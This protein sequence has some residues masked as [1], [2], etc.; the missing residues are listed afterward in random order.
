MEGPETA[1]G[2]TSDVVVVGAGFA[3]LSAALTLRRHRHTVT[4]LDGGPCR[5]QYAEEVHG[6]LGAKGVSGEELRRR[7]WDQV[8]EVG[9]RIVRE[10]VVEASRD[11]TAFVLAGE[12]GGRWR[13]E[14]VLIATGVRD[15]YPEIGGFE[16][17]YGRSVHVCPHCDGYEWRDQPI[18]VIDWNESALP[19]ALKLTHWSD[20][21]TLV[22]DGRSPALRDEERAELTRAGIA[23][24]TQTVDRFR[25]SDGLLEALEFADGSTL[26]VRAAFF[27][28]GQEYQNDIAAQLGCRLEDGEAVDVDDHLRTSVPGVWAAGDV[29]GQ[30][31]LVA[32][33]VAQGV[34]A[35]IDIYRS[36]SDVEK[37]EG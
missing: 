15:V 18:A 34:R 37:P 32:V 4:V 33:A 17:F 25:G 27:N 30:E 13:S 35:A 36:L 10:R 23:L 2:H 20:R 29:A 24:L 1:G 19:F 16:E 3:G 28:I 22:T 7:A 8:E 31:Q 6:Y 26:P 12:D 21:V 9:G 11:G 14:R 5:N